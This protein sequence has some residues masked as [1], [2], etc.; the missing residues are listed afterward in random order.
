MKKV[1]IFFCCFMVCILIRGREVM[2]SYH[3]DFELPGPNDVH[4]GPNGV[5]MPLWKI[6]LVRRDSEF[7]ALKFTKFWTGKTEED[8]YATYESHYLSHKTGNFLNKNVKFKI[9]KLSF[10][11]PRGIGRFAFSFGKKNIQCGSI[12][13]WW[14]GGGSVY[15]FP[16]SQTQGDYGIELAPTKWTDI[17]QV[18]VFDSRLKW[19]KYDENRKR[20]NIPVDQ[21]WDDRGK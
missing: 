11:K 20:I 10:P 15:F 12:K 14:G 16:T 19:Y 9:N 21:L 7:C 8:K 6:L 4:I 3:G 18:N 2:A 5:V 13:L 17:S 1:V